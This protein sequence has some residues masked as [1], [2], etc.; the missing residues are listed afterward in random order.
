[1]HAYLPLAPNL[2]L[3]F[4]SLLV[5][6]LAL[7]LTLLARAGSLSP[8]T[9]RPNIPHSSLHIGPTHHSSGG[10]RETELAGLLAGPHPRARDRPIPDLGLFEQVA[11]RWAGDAILPRRVGLDEQHLS[12]LDRHIDERVGWAAPRPGFGGERRGGLT[13]ERMRM[14]PGGQDRRRSCSRASSTAHVA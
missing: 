14:Y 2:M 13:W 9:H 6:Q 5:K 1:M 8:R 11:L 7:P 12:G 4:N 10:T 3:L